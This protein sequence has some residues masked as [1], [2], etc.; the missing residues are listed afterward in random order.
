MCVFIS[1]RLFHCP[2][3]LR[4]Q[5]L[6]L[7]VSRHAVGLR[8]ATSIQM[9]NQSAA[10]LVSAPPLR[11]GEGV[12]ASE[13]W[14]LLFRLSHAHLEQCHLCLNLNQALPLPCAA[15]F[16]SSP[17]NGQQVCCTGGAQGYLDG[18][19]KPQCCAGGE[20]CCWRGPP[21]SILGPKIL[22]RHPVHSRG[23]LHGGS[24]HKAVRLA[25]STCYSLCRKQ[26]LREHVLCQQ[27][28]Q[29]G[30]HRL[31]RQQ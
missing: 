5:A 15:P 27:R 25:C 18:S 3:Q 31:L 10:V 17:V 20:W 6:L 30:W 16:P 23:W 8:Q 1:E 12:R 19:G 4:T 13:Q 14:R 24:V 28:V 21:S 2:V 26:G 11:A 22:S 29:C 7:T 9:A